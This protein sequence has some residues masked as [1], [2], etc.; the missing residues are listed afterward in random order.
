MEKNFIIEAV[1]REMGSGVLALDKETVV[2]YAN[3]SF[4]KNFPVKPGADASG[5]MGKKSVDVIGNVDLLKTIEGFMGSSVPEKKEIEINENG[6]YFNVRFVPLK[7]NRD[8]CLLLFL[9][10]I[11]EEKRVETIKKDFV[12][13]VSHELRTPLASIKGYSE[14]LLDGGLDEADT[15]KEFLRVIDRHA[16][17]MSRIIDDLL[18]LSKLESHQMT[19]VSSCVDFK[20]LISSTGKSFAKQAMDKGITLKVLI[21]EDLPEVYGDRDR[22]EQVFVNLLDN[23]IK[24]TPSGGSVNLSVKASNGRVLVYVEDTGIG[25]PAED[26]PRIFERFY[27][28]DKA[29]S[30]DMGG[31]GLGLAIVKHIVHGHNGTLSVQSTL[32]KG[33]MFSCTLKACE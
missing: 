10:D 11:T 16:T 25:I 26:I 30:R 33:S 3:P 6:R 12:A 17:R 32:G 2:L 18:V 13:N 29:R 22:L 21:P 9:Q 8:F 5:A 7:E 1:A 31:T 20:E 14:T 27:R 28:V 23:A 24:Y 4:V 19:I 15:A